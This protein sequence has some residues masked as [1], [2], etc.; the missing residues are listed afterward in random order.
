MTIY[1]QLDKRWANVKIGK[2][3]ITVGQQGCT[4]SDVC[5]IGSYFGETITPGDLAVV[6][7]LFTKDA[8]II[9]GNLG[10]VFKKF[11]FEWRAM[12]YNATEAKKV[13]KYLADPAK[14]CILQVNHG[15]H[16][17]VAAKLGTDG[18]TLN[19][20]DP[21]GGVRIPDVIKKYRDIVGV[22]YFTK[23]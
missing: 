17:V 21:W 3:N 22:A 7:G 6:P 5:T 4:L 12:S 10:K 20:I 1:S 18:K 9:W 16:W 23:A 19:V 15:A 2:T 8:K 11:K 13:A 14:A